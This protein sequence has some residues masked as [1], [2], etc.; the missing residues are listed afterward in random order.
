MS[1]LSATFFSPWSRLNEP[2]HSQKKTNFSS[3]NLKLLLCEVSR[4]E[5][6]KS[7]EHCLL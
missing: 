2:N 5:G 4:E 6:G 7:E 1:Y 3:M